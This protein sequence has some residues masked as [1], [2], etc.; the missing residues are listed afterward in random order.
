MEVMFF[1]GLMSGLL[2]GMAL[3]SFVEW[4]EER[5]KRQLKKKTEDELWRQRVESD[6]ASIK[7]M[8]EHK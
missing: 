8:L 7:K 3:R 6:I 2:L 1:V 4:L 5:E